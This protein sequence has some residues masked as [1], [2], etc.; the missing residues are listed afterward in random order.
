[1]EQARNQANCYDMV[2]TER[3][4]Q[5]SEPSETKP[6]TKPIA[7]ARWNRSAVHSTRNQVEPHG[8]K[9]G[10]KPNCYGTVGSKRL[11]QHSEPS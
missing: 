6:G 1:M 8:T 11:P 10:A 9:P 2:G 7:M 4:P 3:W 5:H